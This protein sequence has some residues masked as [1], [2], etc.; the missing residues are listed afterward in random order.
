MSR[1][2]EALHRWQTRTCTASGGGRTHVRIVSNTEIKNKTKPKL[3]R[4][5][6]FAWE[7]PPPS[8]LNTSANQIAQLMFQGRGVPPWRVN[9]LWQFPWRHTWKPPPHPDPDPAR[10]HTQEA[11]RSNSSRYLP[12]L[13]RM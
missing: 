8:F 1:E 13:F 9:M 4:R 12:K 3:P 7:N 11:L 5:W 2:R 6:D 10:T